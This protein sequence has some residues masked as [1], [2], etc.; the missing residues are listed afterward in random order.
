MLRPFTLAIF[1][2]ATRGQTIYS[3][4]PAGVAEVGFSSLEVR[5]RNSDT[6]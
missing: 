3:Y 4:V 2:M 1:H 5:Q 6:P